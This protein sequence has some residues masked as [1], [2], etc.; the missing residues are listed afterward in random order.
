MK[1][2]PKFENCGQMK[3]ISSPAAVEIDNPHGNTEVEIKLNYNILPNKQTQKKIDYLLTPYNQTN[4]IY[5]FMSFWEDCESNEGNSESLSAQRWNKISKLVLNKNKKAFRKTLMWI[6]NKFY[7][8]LNNK[9][10]KS[11][12]KYFDIDDLNAITAVENSVQ[13]F[14]ALNKNCQN[15]RELFKHN[16][17]SRNSIM[18]SLISDYR[19]SKNDQQN[20]K[21]EPNKDTLLDQEIK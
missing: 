16:S 15:K 1:A 8:E 5:K 4:Y 7:A 17:G 2:I 18:S 3:S 10:K 14:V 11:D 19:K 20:I 12:E 9:V 6:N 13:K 21:K